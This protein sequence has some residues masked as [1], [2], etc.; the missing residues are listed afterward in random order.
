MAPK[1]DDINDIYYYSCLGELSDVHVVYTTA[2]VTHL[3]HWTFDDDLKQSVI[4]EL[5]ICINNSI[6][7][8]Y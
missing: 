3:K 6:L 7:T 8:V 1:R 4:L 2:V 5:F